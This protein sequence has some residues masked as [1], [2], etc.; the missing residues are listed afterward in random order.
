[1]LKNYLLIAWRNLLKNK[2]FSFIN[3][4]GLAIGL[5]C[6]LLIALFVLDELSY[7]KYNE[8]A[9]RIYRIN[10][11]IRF[12][13]ADLNFPL[14]SDMMGQSFKQDY[15]QVE[16]YVRI[17][18]SNGSKLV[19]K[20]NEYINEFNVAHADS[21]LFEVFTLPV[22]QGDT[23]TAL[24]GPDKVVITEK[25]AKKYFGTTDAVGKSLETN[26]NG[27]T[28]YKVTAVIKNIPQNS[29]FNF[30]F[31]FSMKNVNYQWGQYLSHNF[32]TYILLKSGTD[33]KAFDKNFLQY[34]NKYVLPEIKFMGINS[35][36]EFT[37][38]GNIL[39]YSMMPVTKIHLYSERQYEFLPPGNI[40]YV[41]IFSGVALFIL[42]IACINFMNL[43]T[44][45]SIKRSKEVGI[46]KV[47]GTERK[48][49]IAQFL[50]EST[51]MVLLS[52]IFAIGIALLVLPVFN[53]VAGKNMTMMSLFSPLLL[54]LLIALP[55]VVGLL[56]GSYPAFFLSGFRPI[57]VLKGKLKLG[58][59]NGSLRSGLVIFQFFASI[60]LIIG[61]I[62]IYRQLNFIQTTNIGFNRDQVLIVNGTFALDKNAESFKNEITRLPGVQ[63][64]TLSS[65]L[66]VSSS[67]RNDNLFARAAVMDVKNGF[68]MQVW[69]VD[70]D[71]IKTLG[72]QL[73]KG[74]NFSKDFGA[75]S[76]AVIINE[77][78]AKFL[79][80]DNPIG[81]KLYRV[82]KTS[83]AFNI[84][85]V[86]KN[87][88]F[89]SLK[90][91]VGPLSLFLGRSTGLASFKVSAA[92]IP[93]IVKETESKWKTLAPGIPYS[94]RF[95]DA[96]FNDMYKDEQRVGKIVLIFS[97]LAICIACL[98]LFGLST[99][100]AE[101]RTKEIGI[102]KV[103]G[104]SVQSI[105]QLVSKEFMILVGIAFIIAVP[106]AW[107]AM[108]KWLTDFV[109]RVSI[110]W[111]VFVLAGGI[112]LGIALATMSYQAIKAALMNPTRSLRA[113]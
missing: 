21:T 52:M 86:V 57:E 64:G 110:E 47:L 50:L 61:T 6:F 36:D 30:D 10:A 82:D 34:E 101:Q 1:M 103:L 33:L 18:N 111:W 20:G 80:Y 46:R 89:E 105:V 56:A 71:Y 51:L 72:M 67:S 108:N 22:I 41:Y 109:Y 102:R 112:A 91:T 23:R 83:V 28:V 84:I 24:N 14:S 19:K 45:R 59:K 7:D 35:L 106:V 69:Q 39:E 54:P 15:P 77:S 4:T 107:W 92:S 26:D 96:S 63:S 38:A 78:T 81:Q 3:I 58:G 16:N 99:F 32:H 13:G 25:I 66:P 76:S 94:Y 2:S 90:Q 42:L 60:V 65:F 37:K 40:Q 100:I 8:K 95:L 27:A 85:G 73:V 17:Y 79:G 53:E 44:A 93:E 29:H 11:R 55:F 5:A 48:E 98:G 9:D 49:L 104:A 113:E 12:G 74:R 88:N 70:Y 62:I 68:D 43:T 87:F 31:F 97:V 75:D